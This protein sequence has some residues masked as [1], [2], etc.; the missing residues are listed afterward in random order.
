MEIARRLFEVGLDRIDCGS[1]K[2]LPEE[3]PYAE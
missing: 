2:F 1:M 3:L